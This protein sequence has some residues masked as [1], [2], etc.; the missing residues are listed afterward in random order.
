MH[1]AAHLDVDGV[2]L[3]TDDQV[4]VMLAFDAPK[5]APVTG[6][7]PRVEHTVIVVLDRSGSMAGG[8]LDNA[9]QALVALV[10][11]LDEGDRFGL[12]IFDDQAQALVPADR[13]SA[14]GRT[15]VKQ[16]IAAV[17]PGG[18]TDLSSGYLRGLQEARRVAGPAGAT[19]LLLS[20]G[21]ANAGVTDPDQLGSLARQATSDRV[22]TSTIG[23]G[24]GYDE[25]ILAA[26]AVGGQGNHAFAEH[27]EGTVV[28]VAG[29]IEGLLSKT[30]QAASVLVRP[31]AGVAMVTVMNDLPAV[32]TAD[33]VLVELGDFY[34]GEER[35]LLL[36]F[37]VPACAALG[38]AN[39]AAIEVRYVGLP[40]LVEHVVSLPVSVNVVPADVAAG[41]LPSAE[42]SQEKLLL[43]VQ[44]AKKDSEE[45][46]RYGDIAGARSQLQ[47]AGDA[48]ASAP[49]SAE[50][51]AEARWFAGTLGTLEDRDEGYNLKRMR[52]SS[53]RAG[54]GYKSRYQ[55]GEVEE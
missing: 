3:E 20:D 54:R 39:V 22:S 46:L 34:A 6:Q 4:T 14:L 12:V 24:I 10:D 37:A 49:M 33:G 13:L 36:E 21:M 32:A 5:A 45:S 15:R 29:E 40:S 30:V 50:T 23:I 51:S 38:L 9:K 52:A 19:V 7:Q 8:R 2:A 16:L 17:H 53:S 1:V 18:S 26:V 28:A 41:R 27:A 44:R 55:G 31:L 42:V 11:R 47:S 43:Q 48:L 25:T 35:R